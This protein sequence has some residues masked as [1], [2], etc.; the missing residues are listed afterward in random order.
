MVSVWATIILI[1][2]R[3][4]RSVIREKTGCRPGSSS[5]S[6]ATIVESGIL[7]AAPEY[8]FDTLRCP[9]KIPDIF[10]KNSGMTIF[11]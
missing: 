11:E 2:A 5:H 1:V 10:C 6:G 8:L 7:L 3:M 4:K 9:V